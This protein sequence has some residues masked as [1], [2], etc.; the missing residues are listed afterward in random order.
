[1]NPEKRYVIVTPVRDEEA[2]IGRTIASVTAQTVPPCEWVVVSDG[3]T[4]ATDTMVAMAARRHPWIRLLRLDARPG[5][6]FA[7]VVHNMLRGI[8]HLVC[9]DYRYIGLLDADVR[10]QADYFERLISCFEADPA[11]GLAGGV[12]IDPGMPRGRIPRNLR[13]V[14]GAVQFFRRECFESIGGLI[15]IPEGGW[16]GMTCAMARM[17]GYE[18]RLCTD[19]VVDHLKP[20]NISQGGA[21]RRKW[22]M[23]VRDHAAG[24]HPLFETLKCLGR[25]GDA[26]F[27]IGAAAWWTGYMTAMLVRRPRVIP[28]VLVDHIRREQMRRM[29]PLRRAAGRGRATSAI[30]GGFHPSCAKP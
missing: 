21:V 19:L 16:D 12:V 13:D 22:Q 3:S 28:R 4:D 29:F 15:P 1:M 8:G 5:R 10:F 24:Y 11:L 7:A 2:T 26:P 27:V 9:G 17:R 25:L 30:R 6:C 18:T 14:P 20:R 23:G